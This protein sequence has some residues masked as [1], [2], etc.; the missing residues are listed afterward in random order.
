MPSTAGNGS[1]TNAMDKES[2]ILL[3]GISSARCSQFFEGQRETSTRSQDGKTRRRR[4]L[5]GGLVVGYVRSY[6]GGFLNNV[7]D[8][9][10]VYTWADGSKY[11]GIFSN[12]FPTGQGAWTSTDQRRY[13]GQELLA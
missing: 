5:M 3:L 6:E 2:S 11:V 9:R 8:G 13:S 7:K 10:G 12:D 4:N 1:T